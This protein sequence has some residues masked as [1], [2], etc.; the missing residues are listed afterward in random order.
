VVYCSTNTK[1]GSIR[2]LRQVI[3]ESLDF[4][5][6]DQTSRSTNLVSCFTV[7]SHRYDDSEK[8]FEF[9][10]ECDASKPLLQ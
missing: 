2:K 1:V 3:A 7:S 6:R 10:G 4:V 5:K 8:Q 9:M